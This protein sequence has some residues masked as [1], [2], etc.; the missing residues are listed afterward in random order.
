[1]KKINKLK[2]NQINKETMTPRQMSSVKGG[3]YCSCSC[4]W[5][6]SGGSS[7]R[8]NCGA[9]MAFAGYSGQGSNGNH[10]YN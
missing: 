3:N 5:D 6:G 8:D 2:L 7:A 10:C 9:N 1:M 4:Y